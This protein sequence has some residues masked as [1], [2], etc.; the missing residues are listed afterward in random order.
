MPEKPAVTLH[1]IVL[2][3]VD[4]GRIGRA[5]DVLEMADVFGDWRDW[6]FALGTK[7]RRW[8]A[9]WIVLEFPEGDQGSYRLSELEARHV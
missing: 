3:G 7:R 5:I 6:F 2:Y 1:Y 9:T 8:R 4:A